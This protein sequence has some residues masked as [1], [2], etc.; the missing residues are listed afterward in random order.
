[1]HACMHS[2]KKIGHE[3]WTQRY[4]TSTKTEI[5]GV[6]TFQS[7]K[8]TNKGHRGLWSFIVIRGEYGHQEPHPLLLKIM[9][10]VSIQWIIHSVANLPINIMAIVYSLHI[11]LS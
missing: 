2:I 10:G 1:M 7:P 3:V 5:K 11:I 8:M 4:T 9:R 6:K